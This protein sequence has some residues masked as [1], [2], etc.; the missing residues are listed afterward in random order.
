[1]R[2]QLAPDR[3]LFNKIIQDEKE[4]RR[5][6]YVIVTIDIFYPRYLGSQYIIDLIFNRPALHDLS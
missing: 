2:R 5:L 6:N 3:V 4:Y 1:L